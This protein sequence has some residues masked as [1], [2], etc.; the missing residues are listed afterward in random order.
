MLDFAR[1]HAIT[2]DCYGTLVD[3]E[4]GLF[5][6][7]RPILDAHNQSISDSAALEL[8]GE[9]EAAAETDPYRSYRE[10]LAEVVT[11]F[12]ERLGFNP[13]KTEV[14][15][16]AESISN[17][18]P[19]PDTVSALKRLQSR[20]RLSIISNIDDDLFATTR[21]KL[22]VLFD[23]VITAQLA[24]SYKPSLNNF[25]IALERIGL[26]PDRLLHVGQSIYHDVVPAQ[27][28]RIAAVWVNRTSRRP[29]VGAVKRASGVPD[30]EVRDLASLADAALSA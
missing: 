18:M 29:G 1:C 12:G 27:S 10:V 23:Q 6:A 21:P 19:F 30:L 28:L 2:F 16:L 15:S 20:Y 25:R 5:S 24:R 17:W 13:S 3:W 4:T 14:T 26:P 8:Y 11:G 9:L 7:L 22:E